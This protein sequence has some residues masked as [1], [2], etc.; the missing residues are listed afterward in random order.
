MFNVL[1]GYVLPTESVRNYF[2]DRGFPAGVADRGKGLKAQPWC[3]VRPQ[4][5]E[6]ARGA[7]AVPREAIRDGSLIWARWL[8][9]HPGYVTRQAYR[10]IDCVLGQSF[11][12][13]PVWKPISAPTDVE[14]FPKP[15]DQV[16]TIQT[17][18]I[19]AAPSDFVPVRARF[20]VALVAAVSLLGIW[21]KRRE[22][23]LLMA[24]F[25]V[26]AGLMNAIA[27]Y[28]SDLWEPGEMM[29]HALVGSVL[30]NVGFVIVLLSGVQV[31]VDARQAATAPSVSPEE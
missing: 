22:P 26:S 30:F 31:V 23:H 19:R 25:L 20:W 11:G 7:A 29:R 28:F 15:G 21:V 10:D 5:I 8:L 18:P 17:E 14:A 4:E 16:L 24:V 3:G 13:S 1:A 12:N 2:V 6:R 9:S 27:S